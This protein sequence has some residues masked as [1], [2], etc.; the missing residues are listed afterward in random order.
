MLAVVLPVVPTLGLKESA[1][2]AIGSGSAAS[3][4]GRATGGLTAVMAGKIGAAKLAVIA[5]AAGS[6]VGGGVAVDNSLLKS[7]PVATDPAGGTQREVRSS[8][9]TEGALGVGP[10]VKGAGTYV[11]AA[12]NKASLG[13]AA[14]RATSPASAARASTWGWR[15]HRRGTG[16]PSMAIPPPDATAQLPATSRPPPGQEKTP[17]GQ[18]KAPPGQGKI[19]PGQEYA[20]TGPCVG[21]GAKAVARAHAPTARTDEHH[22]GRVSPQ[23]PP[24]CPV[25]GVMEN[26][27][28]RFTFEAHRD[29]V[30]AHG[31]A[32][33]PGGR[34]RR[35]ADEN[36]Q[37]ERV[38]AMPGAADRDG[39]GRVQLSSYGTN[40]NRRER[41]RQVRFEVRQGRA[42]GGGK[43]AEA[44]G[45]PPE[46]LQGRAG[47]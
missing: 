20:R 40:K 36:G 47:F 43:A 38:G 46:G 14:T 15:R 24:A 12:T 2:A 26:D 19:P 32:R 17:P 18:E 13:S 30:H 16:S 37:A 11:F 29:R 10:T 3:A 34:R 39:R 35:E 42:A 45:R 23:P 7:D 25:A 33:R 5:A 41:L 4:G 1:L 31:W 44:E 28:R 22:T 8:D 21:A 6:V 9:T 27:F